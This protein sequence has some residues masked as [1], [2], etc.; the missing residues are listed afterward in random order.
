MAI[1]LAGPVHLF[2]NLE[3]LSGQSGDNARER[4]DLHDFGEYQRIGGPV[5][6]TRTIREDLV[7]SE[8]G[9]VGVASYLP[10]GSGVAGNPA[11]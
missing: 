9:L 10:S 2:K 3:K 11:S 1:K 4:L 5:Q 6:W 7:Q 8:Q